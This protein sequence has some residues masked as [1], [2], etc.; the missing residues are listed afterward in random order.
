LRPWLR[1]WLRR[2]GTYRV[3][4]GVVVA[5]QALWFGLLMARGWYYQDDLDLLSQAHRRGLSLR[6]LTTPIND[7]LSPGMRL[8]FWIL[9]PL[10]GSAYGATIVLRLVLQA[11]AT[12]LLYRLLTWLVGRTPLALGVTAGYAL[13]PLLLGMSWLTV[14][15][16]V[17]PAQALVLT[18]FLAQLRFLRTGG[19]RHAAVAGLAFGA[20]A[21]FLELSALDSV[22]VLPVAL[23]FVYRGSIRQ[24]LTALRLDWAGWTFAAA[25]LAAFAGVYVFGDYGGAARPVRAG[26]LA[27]FVWEQWS[28][29][30][31]PA[32]VGGPWSWFAIGDAYVSTA[33]PTPVARWLVQGFVLVVV[34]AAVVRTGVRA[35]AAWSLPLLFVL[36][37][38]TIL[39]IGRFRAFGFLSAHS[40]V[41]TFSAGIP[42][43]LA[44]ALAFHREPSDRRHASLSTRWLPRFAGLALVA[45]IAGSA[46]SAV[47]FTDRWAQNPA[48]RFVA[49]LR[50][51]LRHSPDV[52]LLDTTLP[53][54]IE[55][56][57][58]TDK[59][60]SDLV[61]LLGERASFAPT[62]P[63]PPR[64][65]DSHGHLVASVF[66][67]SSQVETSGS[68][69]LCNDVV[70]STDR[71]V[72]PFVKPAGE[73]EWFLKLDYFEP[74]P[75]VV[76][77]GLIDDHGREV[78]PTG[79][80][81]LVLTVNVSAAYL[82]F[83]MVRP[84]AFV[85]RGASAAT[86]MCVT[87]AA[88]GAPFP[89]QARR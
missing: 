28:Y 50:S 19:L 70:R 48:P 59:R 21:A 34:V 69:P 17:L 46:V 68:N 78:T 35:L 23:A 18:G 9:Q 51:E 6:Y 73:N 83:P 42:C 62:G 14:A 65:V 15:V 85:I 57:L 32:A 31:A 13:S 8:M 10:E 87:G 45:I 56:F 49:T 82:R 4:V 66:V 44:V 63:T 61:S 55:D 2:I 58:H 22:L 81:R 89:A 24:R 60:V 20:A 47:R 76:Y 25:P 26:T 37:C 80:A 67:P 84:T 71:I 54:N 77:V 43:A 41:Y 33:Q 11:V 30:V 53:V 75:S 72:Q 12:L 5:V 7:H 64:I 16:M 88:I 27:R 38:S 40:I 36:L 29:T 1:P 79:G 86:L 39:T 52:R 3:A 74:H